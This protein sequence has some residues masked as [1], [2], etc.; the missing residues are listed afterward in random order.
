MTA[1]GSFSFLTGALQKFQWDDVYFTISSVQPQIAVIL[2]FSD[3][4]CTQ[5]I[6]VPPDIRLI[7][8]EGNEEMVPYHDMFILSWVNSYAMS[9]K[10][11]QVKFIHQKQQAIHGEGLVR[12]K[13]NNKKNVM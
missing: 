11:K 13:D 8:Q 5:S 2:F 3:L 12:I 9:Y 6:P 4:N 1:C 10:G 7:S